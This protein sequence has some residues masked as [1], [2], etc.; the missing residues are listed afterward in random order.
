MTRTNIILSVILLV[1]VALG[2]V[3]LVPGLA[4]LED[5]TGL[6][7]LA[8]FSAEDV[9]QFSIE[10]RAGRVLT[11]ARDDSVDSGWVLPDAGGYPALGFPAQDL[12][13]RLAALNADRLIAQTATS[14]NRLEVGQDSFQRKLTITRQ[15]G[16]S[17]VL[18]VGSATGGSDTHM[19]V[20]DDVN[21]YLAGGIA[22]W[23][24]STVITSWVDTLYFQAVRD[25]VTAFSIEN[26]NGRFDFVRDESAEVAAGETLP[27]TLADLADDE[28]FDPESISVVLRNM[29]G[30]R[31][32]EPVG[33]EPGE[34][35]DLD[36]PAVTVT[37]TVLE[38]VE[39]TTDA[40][41]SPATAPQTYTLQ[42]F[43]VDGDVDY[44]AKADNSPYYV[45]V[46]E[47]VVTPFEG[48]S[49][50]S[51]LVADEAA[52]DEEAD[53]DSLTGIDDPITTPEPTPDAQTP[54]PES[55]AEATPPGDT[56]DADDDG[57]ATDDTFDD[58]TED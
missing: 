55:T 2:A 33:T 12:L 6:P 56:D 40:N 37:L 31:I 21:V 10:D 35:V 23:E 3:I 11:V 34:R 44:L 8:D 25:D 16:D 5:V 15:D 19:R 30:L 39:N 57:S 58:S 14:H 45:S 28:Q 1:Q 26:A 36:S 50:E 32:A 29:T 41:D 54:T 18:W 53:N 52:A 42:F 48:L 13:N 27:F 9:T 46:R 22:P 17:A 20:N 24:I 47:A 51:L 43:N 7:L 4:A 38:P 49:R